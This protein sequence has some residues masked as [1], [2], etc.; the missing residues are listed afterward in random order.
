ML[1]KQDVWGVSVMAPTPC[2]EGAEG[3]D[4]TN[5][6]DL[7]ESARMTENLVSA[8]VG[9]LAL[10]GT[11]GECAAL[12]WDEKVS[13]IDTVVQANKGRVPI[14]AGATG[15]GTK[16]TIRQMRALRDLGA[17]AAFIGLPLWQTPTAYNAVKWYQDLSEAVP[18]MGIM[19]YSNSMFFK[20]VFPTDFWEGV[21]K[22][23]PT[24]VTNKMASPFITEHLQDIIKVAGHQ[25]AFLP[26][27]RGTLQAAADYEAV[28]S[29]LQGLW[30]SNNANLGPEPLV[31]FWSAVAEGDQKRIEEIKADLDTLPGGLPAG[32]SFFEEFPKYNVQLNKW[33]MNAAGYIKAGPTRAPYEDLPDEYKKSAAAGAKAWVELRKKYVTAAV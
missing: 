5:S 13:F 32:T 20:S 18:D 1:T 8:G 31:A 16:E 3:W 27:E 12:L 17:P 30:S 26:Q 15:L 33:S 21:A 25:I 23:A 28:G 2:L 6:V 22:K 29:K 14:F 11:T 4:N 19:V 9:N 7:E 10:C 24:V